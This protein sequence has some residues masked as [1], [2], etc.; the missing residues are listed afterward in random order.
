[1]IVNSRKWIVIILVLLPLVIG[2]LALSTWFLQQKKT[3]DW[4]SEQ[5]LPMTEIHRFF[6]I[7]VVDAND[8]DNLDIYT[9]NH[10]F[11]QVLLVSDGQGS[12]HDV[13]SEWGLDQSRAF[14]NAELSFSA[15]EIDKPGLYIY[16]FGTQFII[17]AHKTG[18]IGPFKGTLHVYDPIDIM[19]NDGFVVSNERESNS[20][21]RVSETK[22]RFAADSEAYFRIRP[23]GQG[24]PINFHLEGALHPDQIFVGLGKVSPTSLDFSLAMRDRHAMV[25][26]DYNRDGQKDI[27]INRGALGGMLRAYPKDIRREL[28]DEL[29]IRRTDGIFEDITSSVGIDKKD[30]SGRHARWLD[31]NNDG[32]LDLYVNCYDRHHTS[33]EFPKQ[34]YIQQKDGRLRDMARETGVGM[35]DQQIGS[36]AWID[37]DDDG[38]VDLV[39]LQNEGFFLYRNAAGHVSRETIYERPLSG[40]QIGHSTES[41]WAYDGKLTVADYDRDGDIDLFSSSKRGNVLLVNQGGSFT[42]INPASA[43]LPETSLNASW[44]DYNNDGLPDLHTVPQGLFQQN[45]QHSFEVTDILRLP[46]EQYQAAVSNWC[47]LD[48]DGRQDLLMALNE[49]PSFE[50]WWE[51]TPQHRLATT[52]LLDGYHHKGPSGHWLQVRL[53]DSDGNRQAIGARVTVV[54]PDGQQTQEVGSSEGAFFSQGHYRLYFGMGSNTKAETIKVRWSDG[55]RQELKDVNADTLLVIDRVSELPAGNSKTL[56]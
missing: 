40:V 16:W 19:K 1:M 41:I 25:W 27:F 54:T 11:R 12:Y 42:H 43:G 33:G 30:C 47:D 53:A 17:Q 4:F 28:Q 45:K 35:P 44:V 21:G 46:D 34:L 39:T 8:D 23:G 37:V 10:H 3:S 36:F 5:P 20:T 29:L 31:F 18:P 49:N 51:I 48:N 2:V 26:A 56:K 14:P 32:L 9:S 13:V 38:D 55:F 15:P 52:W 50:K 6:D 24:L 22:L 7:G